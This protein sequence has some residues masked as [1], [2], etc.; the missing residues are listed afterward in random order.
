MASENLIAL[1]VPSKIV[2]VS[3]TTLFKIA[4][5]ELGNATLWEK[6]ADLNGLVDPWVDGY[7]ELQIPSK[8]G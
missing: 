3:N 6:I 1:T 7:L 4:E 8:N 5:T 2:R